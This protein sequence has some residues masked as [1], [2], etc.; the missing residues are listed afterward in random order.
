MKQLQLFISILFWFGINAQIMMPS[1]A[2]LNTKNSLILDYNFGNTNSY[3]GS[4][5]NVTDLVNGLS[6]SL[7]NSPTFVANTNYINFSTNQYMLMGASLSGK[8]SALETGKHHVTT[9]SAWIYPTASNGV[10]LTE[11][12]SAGFNSWHDAQIE[13]VGGTLKFSV[14]PYT[15]GTPLLTSSVATPLN[16]W[17]LVVL[18]Y[19]GSTLKAYV[20]G[21]LAGSSG[22]LAS[23][24][25]R[26][27]PYNYSNNGLYYCIGCSETTNL[28]SGVNGNFKLGRFR[29]YSL[30]LSQNEIQGIY[31]NELSSYAL[32]TCKDL[33]ASS[34][35]G[36][37]TIDP[38]GAGANA[39]FQCYCDNTTDGGGWTLMAVR[40]SGIQMFNEA[41]A[42]PLLT[43]ATSGRLGTV[44][45]A[46]NNT[47]NFTKIRYTNDNSESAIATFPSSV[48]L[49]YLNTT[50]SSYTSTPTNATVTST[51]SR[52][53][54]YYFRGQS[55]ANS[56]Y[57]DSSDWA[58]MVFSTSSISGY[59]DGWDTANGYWILSGTD[60]TN[61]P[62]STTSN[63]VGKPK[64]GSTASAHW[65]NSGVFTTTG[66]TYVMKT[67][68]WVK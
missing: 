32:N 27:A 35:S 21:Q 7:V 64:V 4:G 12:G 9:I 6:A 65:N 39:P 55:G 46:S 53:T 22:S 63:A 13:M 16:Y 33:L 17:Y 5:T 48:N 44:W 19:D 15:N 26:Q 40:A 67:Y 56:P 50:Y 68:V 3:S 61:D 10:I 49:N 45:S 20:N 31:N 38:D 60:N 43:S 29:V 42:T 58:A 59:G 1:M 36:I 14:W 51:D 52:L 25:T 18:T 54:S 28:G 34:P 30:A 2:T 41:S 8:F 57:S 11:L 23:P 37:Y 62:M 47:L 24:F 66:T